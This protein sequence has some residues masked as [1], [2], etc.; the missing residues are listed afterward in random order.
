MVTD[1]DL[2]VSSLCFLQAE[3]GDCCT[4]EKT[5]EGLSVKSKAE[6]SHK[7]SGTSGDFMFCIEELCGVE[8][9]SSLA[10]ELAGLL[11]IESLS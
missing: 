7:E 2:A 3:K 10:D 4:D 11:S 6:I 5:T 9:T 8:K 1:I